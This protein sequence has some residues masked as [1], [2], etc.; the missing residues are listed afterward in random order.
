MLAKEANILILSRT[1]TV[2]K[3]VTVILQDIGYLHVQEANDETEA[4]AKINEF[5]I[6]VL[7]LDSEEENEVDLISIQKIRKDFERLVIIMLTSQQDPKLLDQYKKYGVNAFLYTP[8]NQSTSSFLL[9]R[10]FTQ[11]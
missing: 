5:A 6:D 1:N 3:M 2:R 4:F 9:K 11:I 8:L 10:L 7:L